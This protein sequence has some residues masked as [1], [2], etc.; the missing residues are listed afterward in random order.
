MNKISKKKSEITTCTCGASTVVISKDIKFNID[1]VEVSIDNASVDSCT[2]CEEAFL[3]N[4]TLEKIESSV[5]YKIVGVDAS[6]LYTRLYKLI[7]I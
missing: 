2:E 1:N 6:L 4:E 5:G 7:R 3:H